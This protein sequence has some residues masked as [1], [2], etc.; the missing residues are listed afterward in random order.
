MKVFMTFMR[1]W[2]THCRLR[3][4]LLLSESCWPSNARVKTHKIRSRE[5]NVAQCHLNAK[6]TT[7]PNGRDATHS[8]TARTIYHVQHHVQSRFQDWLFEPRVHIRGS[9]F[10]LTVTPGEV[11]GRRSE[12]SGDALQLGSAGVAS[13][14]VVRAR[15]VVGNALWDGGDHL[16][17]YAFHR[18]VEVSWMVSAGIENY[19]C[20]MF[21]EVE[22]V[23][24]EWVVLM[25]FGHC[26]C[27]QLLFTYTVIVLGWD[28]L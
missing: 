2:C 3:R 6:T 18:E 15:D 12:A 24:V 26:R 9:P 4:L 28:S 17:V 16:A 1:V 13:T 23:G 7:Q 8:F 27:N 14:I 10:Q 20:L 22:A 25:V 19:G 21:L 5:Q 11:F